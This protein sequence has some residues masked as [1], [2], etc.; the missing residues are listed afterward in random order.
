M[1]R[2]IP[3]VRKN[4]RNLRIVREAPAEDTAPPTDA[5]V[6]RLIQQG[7]AE[8]AAA[9][10]DHVGAQVDATVWRLLGADHDHDDVVHDILCTM[11]EKANQVR[12]AARLRGWVRR[13][14]ITRVINELRRRRV[15]RFWSPLEESPDRFTD[16]SGRGAHEPA[17]A[18]V[19]A[20]LERLPPK[21]R[22][23][24][25]LRH[26]EQYTID[27]IASAMGCSRRTVNRKLA[28]GSERFRRMASRHPALEDWIVRTSQPAVGD[29][30]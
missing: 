15:R 8:G 20:I 25:S 10:Y 30:L 12:D 26:F 2:P 17:I 9:L 5:E 28:D 3:E 1:K 7:G 22:I 29:G 21:E 4:P 13:V 6:L 16:S 11:L 24:V 18:A 23:A 14:A 27:E 19:Y